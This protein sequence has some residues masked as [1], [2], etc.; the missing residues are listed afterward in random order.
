MITYN[1]YGKPLQNAQKDQF[2]DFIAN[3][4]QPIKIQEKNKSQDIIVNQ[5]KPIIVDKLDYNTKLG[6][7]PMFMICPKCK[8]PI[9]TNV[10]TSFNMLNF[11]CCFCNLGILWS[12]WQICKDKELSCNDA[13]HTCPNCGKEVDK[14]ESW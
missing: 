3:P 9:I 8:A 4:G 1:I 5:V 10:E 6:T 13:I 14:Y 11:I 12:C 7:A 2:Q